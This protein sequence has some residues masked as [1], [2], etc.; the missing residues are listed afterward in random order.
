MQD[1]RPRIHSDFIPFLQLAEQRAL[2]RGPDRRTWSLDEARGMYS[3]AQPPAPQILVHRVEEFSVPV[4]GAT[5]RVRAYYPNEIGPFPAIV[6]IHGGGHLYGTL[7]THDAPCRMLCQQTECVVVSVDYRLAPEYPVPV[8]YEDCY[9]ALNWIVENASKVNITP[10]KLAI[11]GDSAGG[12]MAASVAILARD[13]N[14]PKIAHQALLVPACNADMTTSSFTRCE[15]AFL[16]HDMVKYFLE[17]M[18]EDPSVLDFERNRGIHPFL[19]PADA[20]DL[21]KLPSATIAVAECD[22]L[23]DGAIQYANL[24]EKAGVPVKLII[25]TGMVHQF[26]SIAHLIP[27]ARPYFDQIAAEIRKALHTG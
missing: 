11:A 21:T 10:N 4:S 1:E 25:G 16:N 18:V 7:D 5:I 22:I 23:F 6:Y 27:S 13:R 8:C 19:R 14:G 24:L 2:Q 3:R 15:N 17:L 26:T 12:T 20:S 9:S